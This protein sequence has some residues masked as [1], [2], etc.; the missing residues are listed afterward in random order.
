MMAIESVQRGHRLAELLR[1]MADVPRELDRAVNDVVED[2]RALA[3]DAL[4]IARR[5]QRHDATRFAPEAALA[6]AAAMLFEGEGAP[7]VDEAGLLRVPVVDLAGS[8]GTL[9]DRF[10]GQPSRRMAVIAVTGTNGKS[11]V[12][13]FIADAHTRVTGESAGVI[14]TLGSGLIG[15]LQP[16]GLTTPDC[17][18][19]HRTLARLASDGAALA[20]IEASS[21]G[22]SQSRL[23]GLRIETAVFT[24]LSRDHLD[25][26]RDMRSYARSKQRLFSEFTPTFGVLNADDPAVRGFRNAIRPSTQC[27][28]FSLDGN[29]R[30]QV[31]A[32][33]VEAS[34]RGLLLEVDALGRR[35]RLRSALLGRPSAQNLMAAFSVLIVRGIDPGLAA[36]ALS[37]VPA[38]RGRLD[39]RG[40][41]HTPLVVVDYAHTPAALDSVLGALASLCEGD[42]W[43]V[44]GAGGD[45]DKG[46]RALMGEAV[47]RHAQRLVVTDDNPRSEDGDR[48]IADIL[49]GVPAAASVL[50]ERNRAHAIARAVSDAGVDDIVVVAGKGHEVTQTINGVAMPFDDLQMVERA[51]AAYRS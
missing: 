31:R 24:N 11:S 12:A 5:G 8:A 43:C 2:S 1:G 46:K 27:V 28:E 44:F 51:I 41:Q 13:H 23:A 17:A 15:A 42:L 20:S 39:A 50:V 4:F 29:P 35:L 45:R 32:R 36:H 10:F 33:L 14:G 38:V 3:P 9:C 40:D 22:L 21:Q 25:Y 34:R 6:G 7:L 48:I 37:Q 19:V 49:Q 47:A 16:N 26:H 30:A 18:S